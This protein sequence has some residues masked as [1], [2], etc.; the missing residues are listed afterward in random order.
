MHLD[1]AKSSASKFLLCTPQE[2]LVLDLQV[3]LADLSGSVGL[4]TRIVNSLLELVP[5]QQEQESPD[6]LVRDV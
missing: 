6:C 5:S 3:V 4:L 2:A 1:M